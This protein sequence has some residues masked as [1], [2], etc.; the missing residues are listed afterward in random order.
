[1]QNYHQIFFAVRSKLSLKF[2]GIA[3]FDSEGVIATA[4]KVAPMTNKPIN[5]NK[6][7]I[8]YRYLPDEQD[9]DVPNTSAFLIQQ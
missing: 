7:F 5:I 3:T 1:M 6:W 2:M 8:I 4:T 9:F